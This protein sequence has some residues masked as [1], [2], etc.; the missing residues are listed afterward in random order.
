MIEARIQGIPCK[1]DVTY[2]YSKSGTYSPQAETP[3]EYYGHTEIEFD[4]YDRNGYKAAWLARKM[5]AEDQ[6]YI[7]EKVLEAHNDK[8]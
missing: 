7:E 4:V 5:T 6:Q 3:D 8:D 1:I 2:F